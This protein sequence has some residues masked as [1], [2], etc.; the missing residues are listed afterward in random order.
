MGSFTLVKGFDTLDDLY[1]VLDEKFPQINREEFDVFKVQGM[2]YAVT[3]H[4]F[5]IEIIVSKEY[6]KFRLPHKSGCVKTEDFIPD[7]SWKWPGIDGG[8]GYWNDRIVYDAIDALGR[9]EVVVQGK[10][11]KGKNRRSWYHN[12]HV[13]LNCLFAD[14][15][16]FN[17]K[18]TY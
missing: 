8:G 6:I 1:R 2:L 16:R 7:T 13:L 10:L 17:D 12:T 5:K 18:A 9:E 3:L 11:T 4:S 15:T 14:K